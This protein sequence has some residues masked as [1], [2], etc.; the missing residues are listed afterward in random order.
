MKSFRHPVRAIREPFGTAGLIIA[1]VALVAAVGGTAFAAAKLNST[2]KKEVE[3][4]AKKFAGKNGTNGTNGTNGSNGAPGAKGD[5]GAPGKDGT[6]GA[7]GKDGT[8]V[9]NTPIAKGVAG[10]CDELGGA[11]FK[12][13]AGT[14]TFACNGETG[15]TEVLPSEKTEVGNWSVSAIGTSQIEVPAAISYSI[16]LAEPSEHVVFLN[17]EETEE[18]TTTPKEG[19]ELEVE[20]LAAKPVAPPGTLC[21]FTRIKEAGSVSRIA[22]GV[23]VGDSPAGAFIWGKSSVGGALGISGTWAV[24]AK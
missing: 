2:Q 19:C 4:I 13:G 11:E 9:T 1:V 21:V 6:P 15:F 5:T 7:P 17:Q 20:N 12:V 8:S 24:T 16:P 10:K 14:A 22:N 18:S 3:K 23:E